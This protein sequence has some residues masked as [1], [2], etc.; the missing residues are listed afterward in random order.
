VVVRQCSHER[1]RMATTNSIILLYV[2]YTS[3]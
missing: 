2:G 3:Y 1:S